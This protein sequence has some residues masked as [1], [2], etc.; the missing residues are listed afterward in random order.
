MGISTQK[1]KKNDQWSKSYLLKSIDIFLWI[2]IVY[3]SNSHS[4]KNSGTNRINYPQKKCRCTFL[5]W[6]LDILVITCMHYACANNLEM[7]FFFTR[8][9][10]CWICNACVVVFLS[11]FIWAIDNTRDGNFFFAVD[12]NTCFQ[13][14]QKAIK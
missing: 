13:R 14:G 3:D 1:K 9:W 4:F 7:G 11:M 12:L 6:V 10:T 5:L 2:K 8:R